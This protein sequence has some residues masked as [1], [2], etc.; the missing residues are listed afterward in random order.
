MNPYREVN[1]PPAAAILGLPGWRSER[2]KD[3][4]DNAGV[5]D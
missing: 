4:D 5:I 3:E 1:V 2:Q